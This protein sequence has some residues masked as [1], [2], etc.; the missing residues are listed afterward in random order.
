MY[1]LL[2]YT[3]HGIPFADLPAIY[4][5]AEVFA[6]PSRYEGFGIPILEALNSRLPV[7]AATGSCLEE[8]GGPDSLYVNPD[9]EKEMAAAI[10]KAMNPA[11]RENMIEKGLI[12]AARFSKEQMARQTMQCYNKLI[13]G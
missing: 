9:D 7:V 2:V 8:A 5:C 6:Y 3:A 4:Q 10:E 11:Q 13:K 1:L 12:W